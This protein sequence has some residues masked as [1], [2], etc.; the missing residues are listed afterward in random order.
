VNPRRA[1]AYA[2][3]GLT[4]FP[5]LFVSRA[6]RADEGMWPFD[7]IPR[8]RIQKDHGVALTDS[9]LDHVRLASVRFNSGGS[10][11]WV[12]PTGLV[13]TNHHVAA[14]CIGKVASSTSDLMATGFRAGTDGPELPCPDLE[15]NVTVGQED[16]T[17]EVQAAKTPGMSDADAN[18]AIK[19]TMSTIEKRCHDATGK[20]CD[21][22][23][24]YAGGRYELYTY[25]K[26]TD[27]RLVF[28]PERPM[29]FFGGDPEN[30]TYPRFDYDLAIFRVYKDGAPVKPTSFLTW[31]PAGPKDGDTVFVSGNPGST[32][33]LD[34]VAQIIADRDVVLPARLA[35]IRGVAAGLVAYGAMGSEEKRAAGPEL[36]H[37]RNS[38]KAL[39][40]FLGGL[41]DAALMKKKQT[42][43]TAL[44]KKIDADASLKGSYAQAFID[45]AAV[46]KRVPALY[47][48]H[49]L[50]DW[51]EDL[52]YQ[53]SQL[54]R[55]AR[56]LLRLPSQLALPNDKRIRD[57]RDSNL[58]SLKLHLLS[59]APIYGGIEVVC[60]KEWLTE[61][62][63]AM[64]ASDPVVKQV[65]AG[66][67]PARA[68]QEMVAQS[69]LF[70]VYARRTLL[71]GGADAVA[72]STDPI[73][74]LVRA[75]EDEAQA[76]RKTW[77]D[78]V[79]GP[80][81][82]LGTKVAQATFAVQGTSAAPD[83][84]FS[85][86]LSVGVVKGYGKVPW[87]TTVGGAF[88][89]A[90]GVE[91]LKLPQRW[92][93]AK[94]SLDPKTPFNFVSTD[95]IIGGNSGSPV[96]GA[97]GSL[98][99]LVFDGNITSLANRYVYQE[100]TARAVSVDTAAILEALR[101]V[102]GQAALANELTS[103]GT[104]GPAAQGAAGAAP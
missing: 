23:E 59:S 37:M 42:E 76:A 41:K 5:A 7:L 25:E 68:A 9:W 28:A 79:E 52:R 101:K 39:N 54:L 45:L 60:V 72:K 65:L 94:A 63:K 46:E 57:Y 87:D 44:R 90:T 78:Q 99:G 92:L 36:F 6:A 10:G 69:K 100:V 91:P 67:T 56:H 95:D 21:V 29:A 70:D 38:E 51:G 64:G 55:I 17:K 58:D 83:A 26:F 3:L 30:F 84:T 89:H 73:V 48:R 18:A 98:V 22:V 49:L 97:D 2:L 75:I 62:V 53:P 103:G 16:V 96:V 47:P 12:S 33:R 15:L 14:D 85:L 43:E 34:T 77:D 27:V 82:A 102:Y 13:L 40:G 35:L 93:D 104:G 24:L 71:D 1:A 50:L 61:L 31:N 4:A 74:A 88:A 80:Q 81:R 11:S 20:R 8:D 66:R 19:G 86:R 32:S